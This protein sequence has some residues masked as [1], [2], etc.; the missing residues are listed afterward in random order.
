[1]RP[2]SIAQ[3]LILDRRMPRSL[4]FAVNKL[5]DNFGHLGAAYGARMPSL[6]AAERLEA[7]YMGHPIEAI[8]E[9]GHHEFIQD[10]LRALARVGSQIEVDYRFYA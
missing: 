6:E 10:F 1:M 4:A 3:F 7:E 9:G 2:R 8:F 5:L